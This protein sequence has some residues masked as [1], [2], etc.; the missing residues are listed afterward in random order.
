[1]CYDWIN[2]YR[3]TV[4]LGIFKTYSIKSKDTVYVTKNIHKPL[5]LES[6]ATKEQIES[7]R[8][9]LAYTKIDEILNLVRTQKEQI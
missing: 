9:S 4:K 7:A 1:M 5:G 8:N 6:P 3:F 2:F